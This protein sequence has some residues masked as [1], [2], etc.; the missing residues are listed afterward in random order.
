MYTEGGARHLRLLV[1]SS[2]GINDRYVWGRRPWLLFVEIFLKRLTPF[3]YWILRVI[4][5]ASHSN[6][7]DDRFQRRL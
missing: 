1:R 6:M 7:H 5:G 4:M 3:V 2:E